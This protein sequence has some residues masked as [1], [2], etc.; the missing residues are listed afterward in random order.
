MVRG[1]VSSLAGLPQ[2][3][4]ADTR[5]EL[6]D[7]ALEPGHALLKIVAAGPRHRL[8]HARGRFRR[9]KELR[10]TILLLPR[11]T[12]L[13]FDQLA[14]REPGERFVDLADRL[15]AVQPLAPPFQLAER[16]RP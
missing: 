1:G 14:A 15:E 11:P 6:G 13:P 2:S 12:R 3:L 5:P 4:A 8:G 9:T 10:E 7:L 16:L